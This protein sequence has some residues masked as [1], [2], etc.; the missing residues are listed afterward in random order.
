MSPDLLERLFVPRL[1]RPSE[2]VAPGLYEYSRLQAGQT[3]RFH[4][5]VDP[6]GSGLLVANA[7]AIAMLSESGVVIA[8][9]LLEGK[10]EAQILQELDE[11]FVGATVDQRRSDVARV[12]NMVAELADPN[13][14][15]PVFNLEDPAVS[16][17][18]TRLIPPIEADMPLA[19]PERLQPIVER[20]WTAGIPHLT[21][22]VDEPPN[23]AWLV[24]L[25]RRASELGLVCGVSG[26]A[27]DL[28][29]DTL[30]EELVQAGIDHLTAYFASA[31]PAIHDS[32]FGDGDHAA[33]VALFERTKA[34]ELADVA[35]IP[36]IY[37]TL[38]AMQALRVP[39][40]N[41]Y[42]V[43]AVAE[44]AQGAIPAQAMPQVASDV[45]DQA[46]AAEVRY[47]WEPPVL[48]GPSVSLVEQVGR[49][50]RCSSDLA[51]RIE[52]DGSV[53][54][55][56]GPYA[57]AGNLLQEDW[58]VIWQRDAFLRYR[59]RIESPTRCG[60]CPGLAICAADCPREPAGWSQPAG[61]GQ[62]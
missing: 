15:Y 28:Q 39:N 33:A 13:P 45:E 8:K 32:L 24:P 37:P 59:Q 60:T 6:A 44:D 29:A 48:R 9:G 3:S 1:R 40:A 7:T 34:L 14:L 54:P 36:L 46:D 25:V 31:K 43:A 18:S 49:G 42:A 23:P 12:S 20:L 61:L 41:F 5:R 19:E 21:I 10:T 52:P 53:I 57:I 2:P 17:L 50:P 55:P 47:Q 56:R 4:L 30:I 26:R 51:V 58:A 22:L 16:P 62:V 35:H 38:Q 11:Q 27:S